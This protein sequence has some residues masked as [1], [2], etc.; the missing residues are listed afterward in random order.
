MAPIQ[1]LGFFIPLVKNVISLVV[2]TKY[3]FFDQLYDFTKEIFDEV[4]VFGIHF[5]NFGIVESYI[6]QPCLKLSTFIAELFNYEL[7]VHQSYEN[8]E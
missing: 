7:H 1:A 5:F 6:S 4:S 2:L 3:L 8:D